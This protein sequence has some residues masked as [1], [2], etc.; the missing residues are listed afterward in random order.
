MAGKSE[1]GKASPEWK[2]MGRMGSLAAIIHEIEDYVF[3]D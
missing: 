1:K 2:P 3:C